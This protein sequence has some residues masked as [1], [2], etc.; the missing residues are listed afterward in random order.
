M[1]DA[2]RRPLAVI[3]VLWGAVVLPWHMRPEMAR[4]LAAPA[5]ALVVFWSAHLFV[6]SDELSSL[7]RWALL[8]LHGLLLA[9]LAVHCHRLVLAPGML[10]RGGA[11]WTGTEWKY[12]SWSVAI[13]LLGTG[14]MAFTTVVLGG[15]LAAMARAFGGDHPWW[16]T[17]IL[18]GGALLSAYVFARC[19]MIL[20]AVALGLPSSLTSAWRLSA[21][22]GWRVAV[23]VGVLPFLL[24]YLDK[25]LFSMSE[26]SLINSLLL[27]ISALLVIFEV[28]ALSLAYRELTS[29]ATPAEEQSVG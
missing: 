26:S 13:S 22:N 10:S 21:G 14:I 20:P 8:A 12:L 3:K 28:F 29:H 7:E 23:V 15:G 6:L 18:F 17:P 19:T 5:L 25:Q 27:P 9:W 1:M 4:V 11:R 24:K 16:F 2:S